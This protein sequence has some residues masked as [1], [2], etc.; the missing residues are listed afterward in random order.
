VP[1][2]L[3]KEK[4][5][6]ESSQEIKEASQYNQAIISCPLKYLINND[7]KQ[8]VIIIPGF[9]RGN[10]RKKCIFGDGSILPKIPSTGQMVPQVCIISH[11]R[12]GNKIVDQDYKKNED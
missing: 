9:R 4:T 10:V 6:K 1:L 2:P 5:D 7:L 3:D 8:P 11:N 12:P